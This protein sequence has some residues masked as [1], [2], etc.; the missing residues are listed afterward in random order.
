MIVK[1]FK[2]VQNRNSNFYEAETYYKNS[3]LKIK[4][5]Y[6]SR[7]E[8]KGYTYL[9]VTFDSQLIFTEHVNECIARG[10]KINT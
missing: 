10:H 6:L 9:P 1:S 2:S 8:I 5:E 3:F 4:N 7:V